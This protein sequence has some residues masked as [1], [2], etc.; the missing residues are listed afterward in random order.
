MARRIDLAEIAERR[1]PVDQSRLTTLRIVLQA[2]EKLNAWNGA[3]VGVVGVGGQ[4]AGRIGQVHRVRLREDIKERSEVG[5]T[6]HAEAS[7]QVEKASRSSR[8]VGQDHEPKAP[9]RRQRFENRFIIGRPRKPR[10]GFRFT[11][12]WFSGGWGGR[13]SEPPKIDRKFLV[14]NPLDVAI[15]P[16]HRGLL[17]VP[18]N[19]HGVN[20]G[21]D[22]CWGE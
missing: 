21:I 4:L 15:G 13:V 17:D 6:Y 16:G 20:V 9:E 12:P 7:R 22:R 11:G 10:E 5:R 8:C 3:A 19:A 2:M 1:K 14:V 18:S